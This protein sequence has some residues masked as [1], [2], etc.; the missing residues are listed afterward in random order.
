[1][2]LFAGAVAAMLPLFMLASDAFA[3]DQKSEDIAIPVDVRFDKTGDGIVDA[4]DWGKMTAD[5]QQS[6]A[7]ESLKALGEDPDVLLLEGKSRAQKYLEG[8]RSV[9]E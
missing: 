6:Y 3:A 5:E 9:Y 7:R 8:L 1:M 4:S 2:K